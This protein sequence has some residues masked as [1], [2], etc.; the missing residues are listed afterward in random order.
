MRDQEEA[1]P[2]RA[3]RNVG[4]QQ[5]AGDTGDALTGLARW[6]RVELAGAIPALGPITR[7]PVMFAVVVAFATW[8]VLLLAVEGARTGRGIPVGALA[9][10]A[11]GAFAG[12]VSAT[13]G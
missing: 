10:G 7:S 11:V 6:G 2:V 8:A 3:L 13:G 1:G 4:G 9:A 5:V 12:Y